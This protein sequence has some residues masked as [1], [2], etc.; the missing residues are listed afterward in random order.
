MRL[1]SLPDTQTA[2]I[3]CLCGSA[4]AMLT[5]RPL[6]SAVIPTYRRADLVARAV[7]SVLEQTLEDL[8]VVV[9]VDGADDRTSEAL[10]QIADRRLRVVVSKTQLGHSEARNAGVAEARAPWVAFLDDDD[11]WLPL[12]L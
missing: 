12:K 5:P 1:Y 9:V 6:V 10:G 4:I 8:E 11:L 3:V 7:R 2:C